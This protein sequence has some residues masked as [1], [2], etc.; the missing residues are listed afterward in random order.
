MHHGT[1]SIMVPVGA[2]NITNCLKPPES[3]PKDLLFRILSKFNNNYYS[4][5]NAWFIKTVL[6]VEFAGLYGF[7]GM[8]EFYARPGI[9]QL[10]GPTRHYPRSQCMRP[11]SNSARAY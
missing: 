7:C 2:H 9:N 4:Q 11:A 6:Y 1:G 10:D 3:L 8:L 5:M